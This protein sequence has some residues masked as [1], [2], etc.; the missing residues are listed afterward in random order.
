[1]ASP[2][3]GLTFCF[4]PHILVKLGSGT[5]LSNKVPRY[6]SLHV[7]FGAIRVTISS[8]DEMNSSYFNDLTE[9]QL[10]NEN[11]YPI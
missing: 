8:D 1:M 4:G 7:E 10:Y 9:D 11:D 2:D 5:G 6:L 3:F